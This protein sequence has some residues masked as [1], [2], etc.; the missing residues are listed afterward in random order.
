MSQKAQQKSLRLRA[1]VIIAILTILIRFGIPSL[2]PGA[3]ALGVL[4]GLLGGLLILVWWAFFS[5]APRT[6]RWVGVILMIVAMIATSQFIDK[7]LSTGMRGMMFP[8]YALP[9]L[10]A[11]F[12]IWAVATR[13]LANKLRWAL[14]LA[15][16]LL[17]NGMWTLVRSDGISGH[18]VADFKWRWAETPEEQL[19]ANTRNESMELSSNIAVTESKA[20][21][22]GFRGPGRDGVAHGT[23]ISTDWEASPPTELWRRPIGPGCSSFAVHGNLIY[24]QEQRGEE[25]VVSCYKMSTGELVWKHSDKARF[26]DSHA[27]AGPRSTPTLS[28]GLV[29]TFGATGILNVLDA[30]N[31]AV[32]WSRNTATDTNTE[33][34][35]WGF[36]SSPL[37]VGNVVVVALAG[38]MVAYDLASSEQRW[39]GTDGGTGY[40]SPHYFEIDGIEQVVLMNDLGAISVAPEN[41]TLLWEYPWPY[42]DRIMQPARTDDGD[43]VLSTGGGKGMRRLKVSN[44][45]SGWNIEERLS[46]VQLKSFFNDFVIHKDLAFGYSGPFVECVDIV[47]GGRKWKSGRYGGQLILL[48]DQDL[49]VVLTEK[50]ELALIKATSDKFTELARMPA[51]EGKTWNHPVVVGNILLVRNSLEMVAFKL[52]SEIR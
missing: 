43:I 6:E 12:V 30:K 44:G 20:E 28:G 38:T 19:L 47:E 15:S 2:I 41:G 16:I 37:V 27:G 3:A 26:W 29:Y 31:G 45:S 8:S 11:V 40:S 52:S 18:S 5:R 22:P 32:V 10:S 1:G 42:T 17:A 48:A 9:V 21:W 33:V 49:I 50:G 34:P 39:L 36:T 7:S 46:A 23:R 25:E 14:M 24:T 51:I 13:K 35:E 4:G